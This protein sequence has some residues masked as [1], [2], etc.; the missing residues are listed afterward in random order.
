MASQRQSHAERKHDESVTVGVGRVQQRHR[1]G[2]LLSIRRLGRPVVRHGRNAAER[3]RLETGVHRGVRTSPTAFADLY[4]D[5]ASLLIRDLQATSR[6]DG[7]GDL[8]VNRA[9]LAQAVRNTTKYQ[10]VTCAIALDPTTRFRIDD[11]A[12]LARC[13]ED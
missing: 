1:L 6:I 11:P 9:A 12:A 5:A 8:V 2:R 13:A 4:Y 3:P 7:S 10:G